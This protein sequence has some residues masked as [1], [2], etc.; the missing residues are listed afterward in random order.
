MSTHNS[1]Q[2]PIPPAIDDLDQLTNS[3]GDWN[4]FNLGDA[5]EL[6]LQD[7]EQKIDESFPLPPSST[8]TTPLGDKD[9]TLLIETNP[10]SN[11]DGI[12]F[13]QSDTVLPQET[14][15]P[16]LEAQSTIRL[17]SR[18]IATGLDQPLFVTAAPGDTSRLFI[19]EQ[20]TGEIKILDLN[21]N[22]ILSTP[23]LKI[24]PNELLKTGFEQGLLG[25][26][27]HPNYASNGKFYVNYTSPGKGSAG[28]TKI[29]EY[30]V[31]NNPNLA[32][33]TTARTILTFNQP[34]QNHN[35]GSM[36]FGPDGNLYIA[37]GDGGGSGFLP[38]V[39]DFSGNSQDITDNLLGKILRININGDAFGNDPNRNYAIPSNN[40]FVGKTGDDE[41]FAY[42]LRNPW[43]MSF[44]RTTGDLYI[45]DVGQ[46]NR[47]EIN[48][49]PN[50]SSG[51]ENYGWKF[52]EGTLPYNNP[53]LPLPANLVDPI[54]QYSHSVGQSVIGG[55][56]YRGSVAQL[57]GTYFFGDFIEGKIWSFKYDG[58]TVSEFRD[59]T[60]ELVPNVGSINSVSSFGQD[61]AGNLYI[62]DL[63]GEIYKIE[64]I[65]TSTTNLSISNATVVEG[66]PGVGSAV[67]TVTLSQASSSRV[68]VNFATS[69]GTAIAGSD[70]TSRNGTLTFNPGQ[71]TQTIAIPI[72]DNNINESNETFNVVLSNP[73][74]AVLSDA[75][76]LGTI[77]DTLVVARTTTLPTTIENLQLIGSAP[78]DG[79]G[80]D[81][82]NIMTGNNNNNTLAGRGGNDTLI[83]NGGNDIYVVASP[84]DVVTEDA[85]RG[86]DTVR[87]SIS[88]TL[89][90]NVENLNL[91]NS[92]DLNA[93]GNQLNNRLNGNSGRN[94]LTGQAGNDVLNGG[95]RG[96]RLIGGA[97][98][99]TLTGGSGSDWFRFNSPG[100]G[101]DTITDFV[102]INDTILLVGSAFG[103]GL[104]TGTKLSSDRFTI[105]SQATTVNHRVI[106]DSGNG[107][108]WFDRDGS[109]SSFSAVEFANLSPRLNLTN[110]DIFIGAS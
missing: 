91:L 78:V 87:A 60:A 4:R 33:P 39:P 76:G 40:P 62:V 43:R 17:T 109:G 67:F 104:T 82:N 52:K 93:T 57:R 92:K 5:I 38:G 89:S 53:P 55:Y 45:G 79:T 63:D 36:E 24:N 96:D 49:L 23:F 14:E 95:A 7:D 84:G 100:E 81:R 56:V 90:A 88:Y 15:E 74:N 20:K 18:R 83:G 30:R 97:G 6:S 1:S 48:F 75:T 12:S 98:N 99:D 50:T 51:G 80:N 3:G 10:A 108:L 110:S 59:R 41:I 26:A 37:S 103:G 77:S 47:E 54:Y 22:Q 102:A 27:F 25:L 11:L 105:G 2:L 101:I 32:D 68:T 94:T 9:R 71:T 106:Y 16:T 44:D 19:L 72:L 21:T 65:V 73:S 86:T 28:Q 61:A 34:A 42:G 70:Y 29:I 69:N 8:S 13:A 46:S 58:N 31:S 35:G 85:N 64:P 66:Q 107:K